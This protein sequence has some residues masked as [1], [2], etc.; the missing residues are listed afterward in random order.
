MEDL[1]LQ[2]ALNATQFE[3]AALCSR[4]ELR[5]APEWVEL[6]PAGNTVEGRDGRQWKNS[7][8]QKIL[9][10]FA[11]FGQ[12]IPFDWE[13]ATQRKGAM[14]EKAP[15]AAWVTEL[16]VRDGAIWGKVEWN[17]SGRESVESGEYRYL[18]PTIVFDKKSNEIVGIVSVGL[19]NQ[20]NLYVSALNR[21]Q[22]TEER[23]DMP[24]WLLDLLGLPES[25][26]EEEVK[27][28]VNSK[29]TGLA[30]AQ[31]QIVTLTNELAT[32]KA[33]KDQP[34]IA[35]NAV[36]LEL[37]VPRQTHDSL[38]AQANNR[39]EIAENAL[40]ELKAEQHEAEIVEA[41]ESAMEAGKVAPAN[42]DQFLA[43]CRLDGGLETFREFVEAAPVLVSQDT[44]SAQNASRDAR[45][46]TAQNTALTTEEK[47]GLKVFEMKKDEYIAHRNKLREE[48]R[49]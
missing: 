13:H 4:Q 21:A 14:G 29:M 18:S 9:K 46:A 44:A 35:Q 22:L 16:Q 28:A 19:T 11:S 17:A 38:V 49:L 12:D 2:I 25:A 31:N 33:D 20:P 5:D 45:A 36:N 43:M 8:P 34:A 3:E 42:K 32:L 47:E 48:G 37:Y 10:W 24:K 7:D 15:A 23:E 1:R 6:L 41:V 40:N 39:A 30:T 26:S 27:L